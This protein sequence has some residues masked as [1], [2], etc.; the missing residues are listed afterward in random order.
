MKWI[1]IL[2]KMIQI[3]I[4]WKVILKY[5]FQIGNFINPVIVEP[6]LKFLENVK[7]MVE[8]LEK[9]DEICFSGGLEIYG[10]LCPNWDGEDYLFQTHSVKGFEKLKNLKKVIFTSYWMRNCWMNLGKME[11]KWNN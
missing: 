6:I 1:F 9:V 8:D 3:Y 11:L 5:I 7:L 4:L 10:I 2:L